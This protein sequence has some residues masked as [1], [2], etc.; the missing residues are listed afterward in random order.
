M[1]P[2]VFANHAGLERSRG[3]HAVARRCGAGHQCRRCRRRRQLGRRGAC[4]ND[5]HAY[6][7]LGPQS[8]A[9]ASANLRVQGVSIGLGDAFFGG[10]QRAVLTRLDKMEL[11]AIGGHTG[12]RGSRRTDTI[13]GC[14]GSCYWTDSCGYAAPDD[15]YADPAQFVS[16]SHLQSCLGFLSTS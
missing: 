11:V 1:E 10:H 5:A 16:I 8:R 12:L 6:V 9:T 4:A 7:D 15:A 14:C 2:V 3:D 13:S